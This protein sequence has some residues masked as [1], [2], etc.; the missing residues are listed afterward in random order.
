LKLETHKLR[1]N[2]LSLYKVVMNNRKKK[3]RRIATCI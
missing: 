1:T 3:K 2:Y